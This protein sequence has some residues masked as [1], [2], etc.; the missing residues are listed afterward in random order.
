MFTTGQEKQICAG[1]MSFGI[2]S[3]TSI[4]EYAELRPDAKSALEHAEDLVRQKRPN[5]MILDHN[6]KRVSLPTLRRLMNEPRPTH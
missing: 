5:V 3:G 4:R 2:R 1:F 6:G